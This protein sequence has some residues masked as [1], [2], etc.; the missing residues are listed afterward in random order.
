[1]RFFVFPKSGIPAGRPHRTVW[2]FPIR[3]LSIKKLI[4]VATDEPLE[5][6]ARQFSLDDV[7]S[8]TDL[9]EEGF[10]KPQRE[11]LSLYVNGA[12]VVLSS[13]PKELITNVLTAIA[14]SLKGVGKISTLKFFLGR[15]E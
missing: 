1:M 13:F 10:I 9:L 12:P 11:R 6:K 7:K 15:R 14:N 3:P 2:S 5:T 4:A 8:L